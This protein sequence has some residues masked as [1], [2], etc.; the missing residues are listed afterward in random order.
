MSN[1]NSELRGYAAQ[2]IA[3]A[4]SAMDEA[5]RAKW[6]EMAQNWLRF[7]ERSEA[8]TAVQQQQ[9]QQQPGIKE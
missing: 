7:A 6:L 8:K 1:D 5:A 3:C 9:Q 2:C 4:R